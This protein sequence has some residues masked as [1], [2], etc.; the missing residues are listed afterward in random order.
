M[1]PR[2]VDIPMARAQAHLA[3]GRYP[4]AIGAFRAVVAIDSRV[5]GA[6]L[7]LADAL[8][9]QGRRYEAVEELVAAAQ[10]FTTC[11]AHAGAM[12]LLDK[13]LVLD[14]D[15]VELH[16]DLAMLEEALGRHDA[17]VTRVEGLA[18]RYMDEGRTD[19]AA[20][21]LRFLT[22]WGQDDEAERDE[23]VAPAPV[24][25]PYVA[26]YTAPA[27]VPWHTAIIT[28]ETVIARNP[29][30]PPMSVVPIVPAMPIVL[31]VPI[32]HAMPVVPAAPIMPVMPAMAL[33]ST[34]ELAA[35]LE[36]VVAR[37]P[38]DP[39][40][41]DIMVEIDLDS[42]TRVAHVRD[43]S[44][45]PAPPAAR[46]T[47][48]PPVRRTAPAP[49]ARRTTPPPLPLD[50]HGNPIA[51]RLKARAGLGQRDASPRRVD[52]RSTEPIS[53]RPSLRTQ[54]GREEDVTVRYRRPRSL[55]AS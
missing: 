54:P 36:T 3:G 14:P 44:R 10:A 40:A 2:P 39:H 12:S 11:E 18:E 55:A 24:V 7:G 28:G 19:E 22:T 53:I 51:A 32:V 34:P 46:R 27:E 9:A 26:P 47:T 13:A 1:T 48:P 43:F 38:S 29:L 42:V 30:L 52:I 41:V 25:V 17:A 31:S 35:D 6:H 8:T 16:L 33:P 15:R 49:E 50:A 23:P 20:E 45:R 37:A 4:Q 21:L 5:E